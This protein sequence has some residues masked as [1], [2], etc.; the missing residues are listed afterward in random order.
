MDLIRSLGPS[1]YRRL[2]GHTEDPDC[3]D[4][5]FTFFW[6]SLC[7]TRLDSSSSGFGIEGVGLALEPSTLTI[8]AQDL[9][10]GD[11]IASQVSAQASAP[12]A[13]SLDSNLLENSEGFQPFVKVP[14]SDTVSGKRFGP[15]QTAELIERCSDVKVLVGIDA[16]G[17]HDIC[18][19]VITSPF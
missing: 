7:L 17:D 9:D 10:H 11:V 16:P 8:G 12:G 13:S 6:Q 14:I 2:P 19:C 4:R 15:E 18:H 3:F 5:P 1:F